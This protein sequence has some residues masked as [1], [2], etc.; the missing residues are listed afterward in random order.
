MNP[1]METWSTMLLQIPLKWRISLISERHPCLPCIDMTWDIKKLKTKTFESNFWRANCVQCERKVTLLKPFFSLLKH[2][3]KCLWV[4]KNRYQIERNV[5]S[6][7]FHFL[8]GIDTTSSIENLSTLLPK[9]L[10]LSGKDQHDQS[11]RLTTVGLSAQCS[12]LCQEAVK[13]QC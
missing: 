6:S 4:I 2:L 11:A 1:D 10:L 9:K 7:T 12:G 5:S 13:W 3:I 8:P